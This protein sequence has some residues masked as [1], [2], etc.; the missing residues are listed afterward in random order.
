MAKPNKIDEKMSVTNHIQKLDSSLAE[1]VE[2]VRHII[3]NA[4]KEIAEHIKWNSPSFYYSGEM[5]AFDPKEYKRD[6]V[7]MNLSR[8][9]ILLV[10]PTGA[11]LKDDSG[12]LEGKYSDGRRMVKIVDLKDAKAKEKDLK[13]VLK[14]WISLVEK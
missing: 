7:V 11:K 12:L 6:I 13:K 2:L 8:G 9:S 10:F 5:L 1:V 14:Q 3:L 4:H